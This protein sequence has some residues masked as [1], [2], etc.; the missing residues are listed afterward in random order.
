MTDNLRALGLHLRAG[1]EVEGLR[2]QPL[3][4][5]GAIVDEYYTRRLLPDG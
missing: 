3:L 2:R 1:F 5:D 4:R